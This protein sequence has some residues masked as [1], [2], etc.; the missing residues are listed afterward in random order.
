MSPMR[1]LVRSEEIPGRGNY[2]DAR[3]PEDR[4]IAMRIVRL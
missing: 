1:I 3:L 4:M 2:D